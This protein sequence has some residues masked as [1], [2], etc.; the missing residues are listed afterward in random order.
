MAHNFTV[1][2]RGDTAAILKTAQQMMVDRGFE[3][4][5]IGNGEVQGTR[6]HPFFGKKTN[7]MIALVSKLVVRATSGHLS[8]EADL[9]TLRKLTIAMLVLFAGME[10]VFLVLG[11]V[12]INNPMVVWISLI[13]LGPWIIIGP[14]M[15]L[16]FR[17]LA[18]REVEA[19]IKNIA[20]IGGAD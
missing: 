6:S 4:S 14:G 5:K 8:A 1:A 17:R 7:D 16:L 9:G 13:T 11:F 19:F 18:L 20:T 2:H 15:L 3:V 10:S 12:V